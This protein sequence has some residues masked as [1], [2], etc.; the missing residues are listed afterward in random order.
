MSKSLHDNNTDTKAI[1]IP[2]VFTKNS[3]A[4]IFSKNFSLKKAL[5][6]FEQATC[7]ARMTLT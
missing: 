5:V 1:A 6:I 3:R 4:N 2:Q 7:Q